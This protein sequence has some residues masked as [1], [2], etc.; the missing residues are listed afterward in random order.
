V[1]NLDDFVTFRDRKLEARARREKLPLSTVLEAYLDRDLDIPDVDGFLDARGELVKQSLTL[2]HVKQFVTRMV[3]EWT[4]HSRAQDQRIVRDH[5]DRGDDFFAAFLGERMVYT[6]GIFKNENETLEQS[7][8]NKLNLVCKKL[9]L[10]PEDEL[11]DIGCGWGT[12]ALH[13]AKHHGARARG[14]TLSLKQAAYGRARSAEAGLAGRVEFECRDYRNMSPHRYDRI[15]SLE[16]VEHVGIKNLGKYFALVYEHLKD[17]GLFLLQ[18][19][20]LR[21]GGPEGVLP[22]GMRPEDMVWGL[23]MNK[24]IFPGA[25]A[26]LPLSE[27]VKAMERAGFDI[28]SAENVSV[29]YTLTLKRWHQ[30]WLRNRELV[31]ENY[32]ER[33]YRLWHFFLAWSWR[34]GDQGTAACF[35]VV[36]H[37]NLDQF[38]RRRFVGRTTLAA[39]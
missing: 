7:Q 5:Y 6:A 11:L 1:K 38:D 10:R 19:T 16:M 15:V 30:N 24:Y 20:G 39:S 17:D 36:A 3:P 23:F 35:Q 2:E 27:M 33:W 8:D 29:H 34:I 14:V 25:D 32:G 37:K 18:F 28:N 21:R 22:V 26:S 9:M 13:A 31:V 12:L 4:L